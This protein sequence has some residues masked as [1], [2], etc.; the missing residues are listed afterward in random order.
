MSNQ[1]AVIPSSQ[2]SCNDAPV[3][4]E[5]LISPAG[6]CGLELINHGGKVKLS[7]L[8]VEGQPFSEA[9]RGDIQEIAGAAW[10]I[11]LQTRSARPVKQGDVLLATIYMRAE[12]SSEETGEG[13]VEFF[14]ELARVPWTKYI[15]Y[16]MRASY[17][18]K[19]ITIPF[20]AGHSHAAGETQVTLRLHQ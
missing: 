7:Y 5:E 10:D 14:F 15:Q 18:W 6:L 1:E 4:G 3:V 12:H 2:S 19:K 9:I 20:V 17:R 16:Q 8:K 11:Q 13:Q